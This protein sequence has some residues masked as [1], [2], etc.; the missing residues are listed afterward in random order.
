ME[1][2]RL[3]EQ[4]RRVGAELP[5][6]E[7]KS[8]S[9]GL[10][11]SVVDSIS[12]FANGSGGTLLLGLNEADDFTP[13]D[14]FDPGAIRD[15]LA[16]A[17]AN[18]VDPPCRADVMIEEFEDA[19]IVRL[20]V[21]EL[22]PVQKPC[23]VKTRGTYGGSYIRGGDGDRR[24][25]H[26]EVTQLLS[27]RTQPTHD[28]ELV[29]D[30]EMGDL[31]QELV[32]RYLA[33]VRRK[34]PRLGA[35]DD[36]RLLMR[37]GILGRDA[38][39][40]LRPTLAGLLTLG[41]YPQQFFPQLFVSFVVLPGLRMG[42]TDPEGR[43]FLDNE[44]IVGPIPVVV[45]DVMAM[46]IRNM[47]VGAI[48]SGHG[49]QDRYDYP[50]AVIREL[51]VNA[52]MHRDYSPDARGTQVQIE[53]YPDRLRI[54]SPGGLYGP[55]TV[56][57]FGS[58]EQRSTSRNQALAA[59]L[60]DVDQA[61]PRGEPLC[62]NRGSGLLAV[63]SELRRAG[64]SPPEFKVSAGSVAV[65]V[66]QHALLAPETVEWI[67]S[68][69]QRGLTDEQHLALS[70]MRSSGVAS[71]AMLQAWGLDRMTA[72]A[73]LKDL[74]SR[75]LVLRSGGRRYAMYQLAEDA[76]PITTPHQMPKATAP[77]RADAS[78]PGIEAELS[79]VVEAIRAGHTTSRAIQDQLSLSQATV[80]R[81][82]NQLIERD[83]VRRTQPVR[84]RKQ[85]YQLI[86]DEDL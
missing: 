85:S 68:L 80:S 67:G 6:M 23:F 51:V 29:P 65:V 39:G 33:R 22:D 40:K 71:N 34:S 37:L 31:D 82:I 84:S 2:A 62:E 83:R 50:L 79:A 61:G 19:R 69:G 18:K 17:C 43:R 4:M 10:P 77:D 63:M 1:T 76:L 27:N 52:L 60:A 49:R 21:P 78:Q 75:G 45:A 42:E 54:S 9:G 57:D 25:N 28:R 81:R 56:A 11:G 26:Y 70:M 38:E 30:A 46:A 64:M 8:A 59:I 53:L 16:D 55:I 3:V 72:G 20:D 36:E 12:A 48:I 73:A 74:V 44:S 66:P 13:V 24:L 15:A 47:R 14:S 35:S 86:N 32:D 5:W 7:V 41:E 58:D